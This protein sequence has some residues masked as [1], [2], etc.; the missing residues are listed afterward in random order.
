MTY[1]IV[2]NGWQLLVIFLVGGTFGIW[3]ITVLYSLMG[4]IL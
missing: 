3:G 4:V 1:K 2:L